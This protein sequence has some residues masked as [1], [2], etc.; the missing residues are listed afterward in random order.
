MQ[1]SPSEG[2]DT[3]PSEGCDTSPSEGCDTSPSGGCDT[4]PSEGC[5]TSPSEGCD[6]DEYSGNN[7]YIE[8]LDKEGYSDA[9]CVYVFPF[10]SGTNINNKYMQTDVLAEAIF[11]R[12]RRIYL[13]LIHI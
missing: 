12:G 4:S 8:D 7:W 2:C 6:A 1:A 11:I 13:S 5:D 9:A 3:S 10:V